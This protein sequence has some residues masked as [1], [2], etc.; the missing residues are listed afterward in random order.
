MLPPRRDSP[1]KAGESKQSRNQTPRRDAEIVF[2]S[3]NAE[4]A[5]KEAPQETAKETPK[6]EARRPRKTRQRR[7]HRKT[8][9]GGQRRADS[10]KPDAKPQTPPGQEKPPWHLRRRNP[11]RPNRKRRRKRSRPPNTNHWPRSSRRFAAIWLVL[12]LKTR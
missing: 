12:P 11:P 7:N 2:V 1:A 9:R 5:A 8:T 6:Q 3:Y 4:E 10:P